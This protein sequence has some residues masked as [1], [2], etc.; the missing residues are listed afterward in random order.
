MGKAA[1]QDIQKKIDKLM[2]QRRAAFREELDR[3]T[4]KYSVNSTTFTRELLWQLKHV[5]KFSPLTDIE[6]ENKISQLAKVYTAALRGRLEAAGCEFSNAGTSRYTAILNTNPSGT[7]KVFTI[8]R[9]A[10]KGPLDD[11]KKSIVTDLFE[12]Y[13]VEDKYYDYSSLSDQELI[14]IRNDIKNKR[15]VRRAAPEGSDIER[16]EMLESTI[17]GGFEAKSNAPIAKEGG[18]IIRSGGLS[19]LGHAKASAVNQRMIP[20]L[21]G[22]ILDGHIEKE[23][24]ELGISVN[25]SSA[26]TRTAN[27]GSI[28]KLGAKEFDLVIDVFDESARKNLAD[29]SKERARVDK[30]VK[31]IQ[32]ILF[33]ELAKEDWANQEGSSSYSKVAQAAIINKA[34][35]EFSKIKG[36]S[37]KGKAI[38]VDIGKGSS[39][40]K[41]L[42][43]N[44][45]KVTKASRQNLPSISAPSTSSSKKSPMLDRPRNWSSILSIINAKL[46]P[47]VIANM[48]Y[49][50]LVN[51]TGTFANSAEVVNVET[52]KEGF[53]TFV[54]NY[55][56]DPYN[57]FDRTMGRSPWNTPERDPRALV[58]KSVRE[59]VREMAIGRFY[60]RRA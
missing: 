1:L 2:S 11:L 43:K 15:K 32:S 20:R 33:S 49:P 59:V 4:H 56:K 6:Y 19:H 44:K 54:F 27:R 36:V 28:I 51:R 14:E 7:K 31:K 24:T 5:R 38:S 10:R 45:P 58:D 60:T 48:R 18:K 23:L 52:T 21:A 40:T 9:V 55:E 39:G 46:P 13:Q 17:F 47:R 35:S 16:Y 37:V 30:A 53:P 25:V 26:F 22:D 29:S 41:K 34:V 12:N 50:A 57:V 42:S 3:L 8:L